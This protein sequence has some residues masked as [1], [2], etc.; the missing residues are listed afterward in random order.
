MFVLRRRKSQPDA[1]QIEAGSRQYEAAE[2]PSD[3]TYPFL[4]RAVYSGTRVVIER[5]LTKRQRDPS[6]TK[7]SLLDW[8]LSLVLK[9][10]GKL[11]SEDSA[12]PAY[13]H[14][15]VTSAS[16]QVHASPPTRSLGHIPMRVLKGRHVADELAKA[17]PVGPLARIKTI[18][19]LPR[20]MEEAVVR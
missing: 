15:T 1:G 14:R 17:S 10:E 6:A 5:K 20:Q 4:K 3:M 12:E 18:M 11:F 19:R 13:P 8:A 9:I 2:L 16:S 7:N